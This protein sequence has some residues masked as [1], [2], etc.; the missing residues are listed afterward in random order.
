MIFGRRKPG[1]VQSAEG[2]SPEEIIENIQKAEMA[3]KKKPKDETFDLDAACEKVHRMQQQGAVID[4]AALKDDEP[5]TAE[6]AAQPTE[7]VQPEEAAQ[8]EKPDLLEYLVSQPD[9]EDEFADIPTVTKEPEP[10]PTEAQKLAGYIRARSAAAQLTP[11]Q[12]LCEELEEADKTLAEMQADPECADIVCREGQKDRYY[13]SEAAMSANYA[14][15]AALIADDDMCETIAQMVRFNAKT[16]P[17]ATP[18][19]YF[20]R[21]PYGYTQEQIEQAWQTMQGKEQFADIEQLTNNENT[22]FLFSTKHLTRRYA[23]AISNVDEFCD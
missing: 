3:A 10:E 5:L 20:R 21:K 2:A 9:R 8:P 19:N 4:G 1:F 22:K 11:Y 23:T 15:I 6:P 12:Q 13:Y 16:Y 7:P 18:M 14:M 17:C